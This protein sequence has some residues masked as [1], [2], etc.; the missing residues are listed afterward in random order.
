MRWYGTIWPKSKWRWEHKDVSRTPKLCFLV[1]ICLT[2]WI[3]PLVSPALKG[4]DHISRS[5]VKYMGISIKLGHQRDTSQCD[6]QKQNRPPSTH[7][8][9]PE[10]AHKH[11][12]LELLKFTSCMLFFLKKLLK[13]LIKWKF[14]TEKTS[15]KE[16]YQGKEGCCVMIEVSLYPRRPVVRWGMPE[17]GRVSLGMVTFSAE[18]FLGEGCKVS[19]QPSQWLGKMSFFRSGWHWTV[20]MKENSINK[21]IN[22]CVNNC[23]GEGICWF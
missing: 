11:F 13:L 23:L 5:G 8:Q 10:K 4:S 12:L 7:W 21:L 20:F 3:W 2:W 19:W 6:N 15:S 18:V 1:S 16:V 14:H 17:E 9:D 22:A